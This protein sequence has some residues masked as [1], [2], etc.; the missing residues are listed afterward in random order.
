MPIFEITY[1]Q[2]ALEPDARAKLMDDLT[3]T[4]LH[5]ERAPETGFFRDVTWGYVHEL[6][7]DSVIASGRPVTAPTF[8]IDVTTPEGALSDRRREEY[9][10]EATRLVREAAGIREEEGLRVFILMH[11][12]A[13]GSWGAAGQVIRFSQLREIAKEQR[14]Q[15]AQQEQPVVT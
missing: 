13:D 10:A 14:E 12:V 5:A 11:E 3:T 1:P 9:V 8:K 15:A 4:L 6:P 2:G 7:A